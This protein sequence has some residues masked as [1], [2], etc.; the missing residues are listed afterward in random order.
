MK[1]KLGTVLRFIFAPVILDDAAPQTPVPAAVNEKTT[2]PID[3]SMIAREQAHADFFKALLEDDIGT[4]NLVHKGYPSAHTWL[5][6]VNPHSTSSSQPIPLIHYAA[7]G[8]GDALIWLLDKGVDVETIDTWWFKCTPLY[9]AAQR[10][11]VDTVK[12]LLARG[13]NPYAVSLFKDA[14][15][16]VGEAAYFG[17]ASS[18]VVI[19]LLNEART[20]IDATKKPPLVARKPRP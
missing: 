10:G 20:K 5:S 15:D 14:R 4:M 12:I 18:A 9:L 6:P 11:N 19:A 7:L 2:A 13:A 16:M 3:Y 1:K 17:N 8:C